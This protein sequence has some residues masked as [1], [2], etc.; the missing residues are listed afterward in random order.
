MNP[1]KKGHEDL[2]PLRKTINSAA[3]RTECAAEGV[4]P[5]SATARTECAA[6]DVEPGMECHPCAEGI[7]K[8]EAGKRKTIRAATPYKPSQAEVEDHDLTHLPYRSLCK[9]CIRG[10]GKET[11]HQQQCGEDRAVP[12]FHRDFCFPGYEEPSSEYLHG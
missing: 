9:H 3:G 11:G 10:R 7:D 6:E 2:R 1:R 8:E 5:D 12:E 4:E